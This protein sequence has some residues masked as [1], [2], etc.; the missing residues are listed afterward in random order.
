MDLETL[1]RCQADVEALGRQVLSN[2]GSRTAARELHDL[3]RLLLASNRF[4]HVNEPLSRIAE[5][6][7]RI[8][9]K[10]DA[11]AIHKLRE[12]LHQLTTLWV[13]IESQ[14]TRNSDYLPM[15]SKQPNCAG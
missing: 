3:S 10:K 7:A 12:A 1:K 6:A 11:T 5:A 14:T 15:A 8:G 13:P 2:G 9:L 4:S